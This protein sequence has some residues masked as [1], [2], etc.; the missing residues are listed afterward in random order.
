MN[1][2]CSNTANWIFVLMLVVPGSVLT[3]EDTPSNQDQAGRDSQP[4]STAP[5]PPALRQALASSLSEATS[6]GTK[7]VPTPP[8]GS[9]GIVS[10]G[11]GGG[12][13]FRDSDSEAEAWLGTNGYG[14]MGFGLNA[15]GFFQDSN[16][17]GYA[18]VGYFN[19][20]IQGHGTYSGG[21][22]G[23]IASTGYAYVGIEHRGIEAYGSE[24]GG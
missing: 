20:G 14:V 11:D 12:G 4:A 9:W 18:Y 19:Y 23:A 5:V 7:A 24:M 6:I 22:F 17:S 8:T 15:G 1:K 2:V 21:Y 10:E 3:A 16:S 13:I